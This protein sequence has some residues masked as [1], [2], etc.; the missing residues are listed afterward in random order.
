MISTQNVKD[1]N[2]K[3]SSY[4]TYGPGEYKINSFEVN[5]A[6]TGAVRVRM[7]MESRPV[8]E[9]GFE[10]VDGAVGKVGRV[11][12]TSY[13][14][15]N[16]ASYATLVETFTRKMAEIADALG[17][18]DDINAIAAETIEEYITKASPLLVNKFT[19]WVIA[20]EEYLNQEDEVR[21][22]LLIP[23]YGFVSSDPTRLK[24][25]KTSSYHF[26]P[27]EAPTA[28]PTDSGTTAW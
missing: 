25:D 11:N 8:T 6:S 2:N 15:P 9:A 18:R 26:K 4:M 28:T 7:N 13:M 19:N 17:V 21:Y 14:N 22:F 12:L 24:F 27:V 3:P 23:R 1:T 20:A 5:T 10:G 16:N